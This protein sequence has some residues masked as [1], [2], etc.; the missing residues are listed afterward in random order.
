MG[1]W[2]PVVGGGG[3][4]LSFVIGQW[5]RDSH[6]LLQQAFFYLGD[7]FLFGSL[8]GSRFACAVPWVDFIDRILSQW[9]PA[10]W[11]VLGL[12]F[13]DRS[14]ISCLMHRHTG[15]VCACM[16][17]FTQIAHCIPWM[18][19]AYG[20]GNSPPPLRTFSVPDISGA[21]QILRQ[22]NW[23][24]TEEDIWHCELYNSNDP[25]FK[26]TKQRKVVLLVSYQII[27][28]FHAMHTC[29]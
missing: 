29:W 16:S 12:W 25:I 7:I 11:H 21:D 28:H 6:I 20:F 23:S 3:W 15:Y 18:G 13:K 26:A 5:S 14:W 9:T 24:N 17:T 19:Y 27:A 8:T 22:P 10:P 2:A 1:L 4:N